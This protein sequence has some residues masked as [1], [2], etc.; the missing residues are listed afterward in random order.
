MGSGFRLHHQG[1]ASH[2]SPLRPLP[3]L[4]HHPLSHIFSP[5]SKLPI[6]TLPICLSLYACCPQVSPPYT[7]TQCHSPAHH[8]HRP[9]TSS[10]LLM[11]HRATFF[12]D[13][14]SSSSQTMI[15]QHWA[16]STSSSPPPQISVFLFFF[17]S[18]ILP[19]RNLLSLSWTVGVPLLVTLDGLASNPI[20]LGETTRPLVILISFLIE[21]LSGC[22]SQSRIMVPLSLLRQASLSHKSSWTLLAENGMIVLMVCHILHLIAVPIRQHLQ[23]FY[24]K[25]S[26]S[27][28]CSA[29]KKS[30]IAYP[31]FFP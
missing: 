1:R 2:F 17:R 5:S 8:D 10:A 20:Q 16:I 29:G 14:C 4:H 9:P 31:T 25:S 24:C 19:S 30:C 26:S 28:R 11:Y 18:S 21:P 22:S 23:F 7:Y 12:F 6:S 15:E 13:T 3:S 27:V